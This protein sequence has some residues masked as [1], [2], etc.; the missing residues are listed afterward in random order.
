MED[1]TT[2]RRKLY[3]ILIALPNFSRVS[4][5]FK[6]DKTKCPMLSNWHTWLVIYSRVEGKIRKMVDY[7]TWFID[8]PPVQ[9]ALL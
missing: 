4:H 3:I 2:I 6:Y 5:S 9:N 7:R 8:W 1:S